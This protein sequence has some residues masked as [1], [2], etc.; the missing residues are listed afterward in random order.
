M[1]APLHREEIPLQLFS[2]PQDCNESPLERRDQIV[3]VGETSIFGS[4]ENIFFPLSSLRKPHRFEGKWQVAS[5]PAPD[6]DIGVGYIAGSSDTV[7]ESYEAGLTLSQILAGTPV[8]GVTNASSGLESIR[9]I[10]NRPEVDLL[11]EIWDEH[12]TK[13]F[14]G[15]FVQYFSRDSCY[16]V[17][18]AIR[19]Y[20][21]GH[22]IVAVGVNADAPL[23]HNYAYYFS[24]TWNFRAAFN[25]IQL[26]VL[27]G[28]PN[29]QG[30]FFLDFQDPVF[31]SGLQIA[32]YETLGK[33][34]N[35][36]LVS[37]IPVT[38]NVA[39]ILE[40]PRRIRRHTDMVEEEFLLEFAQRMMAAYQHA[41]RESNCWSESRVN[42]VINLSMS[43]LRNL[44]YQL[45]LIQ[46]WMSARDQTQH[47]GLIYAMIHSLFA[48]NANNASAIFDPNRGVFTTFS[49]VMTNAT[50]VTMLGS[51]VWNTTFTT[52]GN[53]ITVNYD[54]H[55]TIRMNHGINASS[56][57]EGRVG[58]SSQETSKQLIIDE[59]LI[60]FFYWAWT[61]HG[62]CE[63]LLVA[64]DRSR[65]WKCIRRIALAV[66]STLVILA[67]S[68][69][70]N[71]FRLAFGYSYGLTNPLVQVTLC[72][73]NA[74]S[75]CREGVRFYLPRVRYY[76]QY[77]SRNIFGEWNFRTE[78]GLN[79]TI[80]KVDNRYRKEL[81]EVRL[82]GQLMSVLMLEAVSGFFSI[83]ALVGD[84]SSGT[85]AE[86]KGL[87]NKI[88]AVKSLLLL[89][90]FFFVMA[91]I[92][93][94]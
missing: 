6:S 34:P 77:C 37:P 61:M 19:R 82:F 47:R 52:E 2:P 91:R 7:F 93:K 56:G 55:S 94:N 80:V 42:R 88:F 4:E 27:P 12:F 59:C 1:V 36:D 48:Q 20:W 66:S 65:K 45:I 31:I 35:V 13:Y 67:L 51:T 81:R 33:S 44:D 24:S 75:L 32:Y 89:A 5:H 50:F 40:C 73:Y 38:P 90:V 41:I 72:A 86:A 22:R 16:L 78:E 83:A 76:V 43:Y 58:L 23:T 71:N 87:I 92:F 79:R 46:A 10:A 74:I 84:H 49:E 54:L 39:R 69:C 30:L 11:V 14:F 57:Y 8:Q 26:K 21:N 29:S 64:T 25:H 3:Y 62:F 63:A 28:D 17:E 60:L 68:D 9:D 53:A 15:G 85:F 70:I 18:C